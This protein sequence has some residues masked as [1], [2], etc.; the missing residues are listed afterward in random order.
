MLGI[1][2]NEWNEVL[3]INVNLKDLTSLRNANHSSFAQ[4][5]S[6]HEDQGVCEFLAVKKNRVCDFVYIK[7]AEFSY[8]EY[9]SVFLNCLH[10][11]RE[12]S[13][14]IRR[15]LNL[16]AALEF[17]LVWSRVS[18]FHE[19]NLLSG[20]CCFLLTEAENTVFVSGGVGKWHIGEAPSVSFENLLLSLFNEEELHPSIDR[21]LIG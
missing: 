10:E 21:S 11:N 18:D 3:L 12:V 6:G 4:G 9:N 1:I 17:L 20:L 8:H 13:L 15:H 16:Y 5:F 19:M 7:V 14:N 2:N